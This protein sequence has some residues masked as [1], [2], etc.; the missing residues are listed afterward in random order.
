ME[1]NKYTLCS[2]STLNDCRDVCSYN[3]DCVSCGGV[4][5]CVWNKDDFNAQKC[6]STTITPE[7]TNT[8]CLTDDQQEVISDA[9]TDIITG[10][11]SDTSGGDTSDTGSS[12]SDTSSG[13]GGSSIITTSDS[14][15]SE[16]VDISYVISIVVPLL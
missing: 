11:D 8:G 10:G 4:T 14:S 9:I 13:N 6:Q 1:C 12:G 7:P 3:Y 15:I 16:D 5:G 2:W